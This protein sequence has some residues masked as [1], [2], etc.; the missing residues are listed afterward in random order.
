VC[1]IQRKA[2]SAARAVKTA[3]ARA[4]GDRRIESAADQ[5]DKPTAVGDQLQA[6][7]TDVL[8]IADAIA[9]QRAELM[10]RLAQ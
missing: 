4:N 8:R 6:S 10:D 3:A 5:A 2:Y 1:E 7:D 9:E